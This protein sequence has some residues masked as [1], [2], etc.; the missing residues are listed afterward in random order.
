LVL[1]GPGEARACAQLV[2]AVGPRAEVIC[3]AGFDAVFAALGRGRACVAGDTGLAH[4]CAAA[5]MP[6][7][8]LFGGTHASDGFWD[9]RCRPVQL[10]LPCRPCAR[11]GRE[12]C[13]FGDLRCLH[14]LA[15]TLVV[16]ALKEIAP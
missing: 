8:T 6:V 3:E 10:D 13:P 9:D 2:D 16:A 4:L 5:G 7:V 11:F 12:H 1:G 15:P 14:E